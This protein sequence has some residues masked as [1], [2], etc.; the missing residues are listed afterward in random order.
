MSDTLEKILKDPRLSAH[1]ETVA[2]AGL[3]MMVNGADLASDGPDSVILALEE[4]SGLELAQSSARTE[5]EAQNYG[6]LLFW[7]R[8]KLSAV[9]E[10]EKLIKQSQDIAARKAFIARIGYLALELAPLAAQV[11][12]SK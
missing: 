10:K 2:R 5:K 12:M 9:I 3:G 6:K 11:A 4:V 7:S 8:E 1:I